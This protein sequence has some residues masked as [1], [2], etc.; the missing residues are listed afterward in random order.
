MDGMMRSQF[1]DTK[2]LRC[3][4][5]RAG[6]GNEKRLVFLHGNLSSSEY[7]LP[8][9]PELARR[10]DVVAP[11]LRCFGKTEPL[12]VDATRGYRD[13]SDDVFSLVEALGWDEKPFVLCGW[14]M[15]G[16]VAMQFAVDH[17]GLLSHLVLLAP[18]SPYGFG[19]TRDACGTP[20]EP[21]GLGA[22]AGSANP[23]LVF[24]LESKSRFLLRDILTKYYFNP[25]FRM[26]RSWENRLLDALGSI[27]LGEDR[28]PGNYSTC[29]SWPYVVAG[30][31]GVL[32]TMAPPYADLS[33]FL[34]IEPKPPVLWIRGREDRIVSDES[35]ME[36]GYLG[37]LGLVPGW[38]GEEAYP[39]QP[40]VSQLQAFFEKYRACG[41]DAQERVIDGGHM[42]AL[43]APEQFFSALDDF[44]G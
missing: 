14:S 6:Q 34:D 5:Y 15:G 25:P 29:S 1:L 19:G 21:V 37:K 12:A 39:P 22:G 3:A 18:G 28:Y 35:L 41:G 23:G 24:A 44:I 26:E 17:A 8:L 2:R 40:M 36:F 27:A 42:C 38:P 7:V 31:S 11:D 16:N 43:E 30:D 32:N 9:F 33:A 10:F 13:W 20:H 4:F